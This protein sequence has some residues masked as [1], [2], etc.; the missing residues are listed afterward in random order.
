MRF[1][2]SGGILL[3]AIFGAAICGLVYELIA[4]ALSSYLIGDSVTQFSMVI[5]VFLSAM[6]VG[7][8]L[9][10]FCRSNLLGWLVGIE[11]VVGALGGFTALFGFVAF[12]YTPFYVPILLSLM[13]IVG[14]LVGAEIPLVIRVLQTDSS[15]RVNLANVLGVDYLGALI[16][17]LLFPFVLLPFVGLIRGG[18]LMGLVNVM[19]GLVLLR[20]FKRQIQFKKCLGWAGAAIV[21][22]MTGAMVLAGE[23]T[24]S[25][26]TSLYQDTIVFA[27]NTRYQRAVIT[28][29]R[30]DIRLYLNGHLQ[31]SSIDEYRYHEALVHPAFS[32][33][34]APQRIL[35]LGGGDGLAAREIL[36]YPNVTQVDLVDLDGAITSLFRENPM[37]T[38]LNEAS[39]QD[40]RV[41]I[42]NDDAMN[43]LASSSNL[44]DIILMDLPDP[45]TTNIGKLYS[46]SFFSLVGR[47]LARDGI[48][49]TQATSPYRS[50]EAFWSI[51]ATVDAARWGFSE[52]EERFVTK[53][54]HVMI[55]TFGIWGFVLAS[56]TDLPTEDLDIR[57]STRYVTSELA[58][59]FFVFPPDMGRIEVPVSSLDNPSV[60]RLYSEGYHRYLE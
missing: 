27:K 56:R 58:R 47:R 59:S 24:K 38:A 28:R 25:I 2:S 40:Q 35:I 12:A 31:F 45:S 23:L 54:Y 9:S 1:P 57:V 33:H 37:L 53:P 42:Y 13:A 41:T 21:L 17:S 36:R 3:L 7:S 51:A 10:R 39:L 26:E 18:I 8:F 34:P 55:P 52:N 4:G 5:G 29:W 19:I 60:V 20:V 6:G 14:I 46:R 49:C 16:A 32:F 11:L 22:V 48:L 15:L 30:D 43:F 50:R 44:Y